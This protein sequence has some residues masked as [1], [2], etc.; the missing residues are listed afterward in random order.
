M[1]TPNVWISQASAD[2][3]VGANWSLTTAPTVNNAVV[4]INSLALANMS[5]NTD[6]SSYSGQT[7]YLMQSAL[8]SLQ[9]GNENL[10]TGAVVELKL[11]AGSTVYNYVVDNSNG[12]GVGLAII[13]LGTGST[14]ISYGSSQTPFNPAY[15]AVEFRNGG[16]GGAT[17]NIYGGTIGIAVRPG[18][19][20]NIAKLQ[21]INGPGVGNPTASVGS[22]ATATTS[23]VSAGYVL[24]LSDA[25]MGN[26]TVEGSGKYDNNGA[27]THTTINVAGPQATC[28]YRGTGAI[29]LVTIQGNF[30]GT[31]DTRAKTITNATAYRSSTL[32]LNN[33]VPGAWTVS[34]PIQTP[35]GIGPD[36]ATI[37]LPPTMKVTIAIGP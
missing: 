33:G 15:P 32:N 3:S 35:D 34:N 10:A 28:I 27:A 23:F 12:Q 6:F 36:G 30:D 16:T 24:S 31:Q 5:T 25:A 4:V 19:S 9:L 29:T 20:A 18:T 37:I 22:G 17:F 2:A 14:V 11:G 26:V 13:N 21:T 7:W 8:S 1:T